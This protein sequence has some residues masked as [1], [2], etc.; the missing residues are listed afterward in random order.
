MIRQ[1]CLGLCEQ[2][3]VYPP[4]YV[5]EMFRKA[6]TPERFIVRES[7]TNYVNL[8]LYSMTI[9]IS[10]F[11]SPESSWYHVDTREYLSKLWV[12]HTIH[13]LIAMYI[14]VCVNTLPTFAMKTTFIDICTCALIGYAS[15][16]E[17]TTLLPDVTRVADL[18]RYLIE[19]RTRTNA[20]SQNST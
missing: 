8:T 13:H 6:R 9:R 1:I 15:D 14:E 7:D 18:R 12:D 4:N 5:I 19:K 10:T 3:I 20:Q 17:G 11:P 16:D 2:M